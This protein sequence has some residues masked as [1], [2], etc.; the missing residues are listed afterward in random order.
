MYDICR[1]FYKL[2]FLFDIKSWHVYENTFSRFHRDSSHAEFLSCRIPPMQN[3]SQGIPPMGFLGK[4]SN[5]EESYVGKIL[6]G[7]NPIWEES[8][9]RNPVWEESGVE[10]ILC[11]ESSRLGV[12]LLGG[13][14]WEVSRWEEFHDYPCFQM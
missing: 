2:E 10:G 9:G 5:G 8:H 13:I 6:C 14:L 11:E 12:I 4:N 7:R 3:S 1:I